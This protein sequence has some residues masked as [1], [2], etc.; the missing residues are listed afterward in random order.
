MVQVLEANA[1]G[2]V[3]AFVEGRDGQADAL[4]IPV[5]GLLFHIQYFKFFH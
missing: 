5:V 2:R 4:V 3:H 1:E